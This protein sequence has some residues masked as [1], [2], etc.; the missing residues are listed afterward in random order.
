M[1]L[2]GCLA[3]WDVWPCSAITKP[4]FRR[5][6]VQPLFKLSL[7][8]HFQVSAHLMVQLAAQFGPCNFVPAFFRCREMNADF[9]ARHGI[10]LQSQD[11]HKKIVRHVFCPQRDA[12]GTVH[13]HDPQGVNAK[14]QLRDR[15]PRD[16]KPLQPATEGFQFVI[17]VAE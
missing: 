4:L 8:F 2:S 16:T 15:S 7:R 5:S 17:V 14:L 3:A 11:R 6:L 13:R 12:D 9:Q 1:K 10:L